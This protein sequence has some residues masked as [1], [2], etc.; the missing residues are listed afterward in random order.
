MSSALPRLPFRVPGLWKA[1]AILVA[2]V[3]ALFATAPLLT[4]FASPDD[5][6]YILVS[7]AHYINNGHLYTQTFSQY[8]PLYFYIQGIF[9]Q[10]LHLPV[11]HDM[12]RLV[13]LVYWAASSLLASVFVHRLSKSLVLACAA[14]LCI[15][16]AGRVLAAEPGHPQQVILLLYM[17]A[18]CLSLPSISGRYYLRLLLLGCVG[19]ALVFT[20]VNVGVFYVAGVAHA[21]VC[22]LPS[23]RFRSIGVGL[24]LIYAAVSPWLLMHA[25]LNNGFRGYFLLA[26]VSGIVTFGCGSLVRPPHHL[27]LRAAICAGTGL[28]AGAVVLIIATSVQG[29]SVGSLFWGVILNPLSHPNV[30]QD[31]LR[32]TR[33][34]LLAALILTAGMVGLRSSGRR[35]AESRWLDALRCAAGIG[36]ILL[37]TLHH[38]IEL[39][40]PLLPLTL[41]PQSHWERDA[42]APFCRLFITYMAVTQFLEPYPVAGSQVAIAAAPMILWAF[43]CIADGIAGLRAA[44]VRP[45]HDLGKG[46][47]LDEAIG[48]AILIYFAGVSVNLTAH[49][50]FPPASTKLN[51]SEWLHLPVEQARQFESIARLANINCSTLFSMPGMGSFNMWS[52]I[53][54]PNGWFLTLWMKGVDA[55]RQAEI[56]SIMKSDPRACAIVNR[57]LVRAWVGDEAD[58]AA[59]PLSRFIMTDMIK[60]AEFGD[61]EISVHPRRTSPWL[62]EGVSGARPIAD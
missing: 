22:L 30:Y 53:P 45:F 13:T 41:I 24:A 52:G 15:M 60:V 49:G 51:G 57:P 54:T 17:I 33:L 8:G 39:V 5:E 12:G 42:V 31:P 40:A 47:R 26:T 21:V 38:R 16:L 55:E 37:L 20:K 46:L 62:D 4:S 18:A 56:L 29:M 32:V 3:G 28:L 44:S 61:Y 23:S 19:A 43:L 36:S 25:G 10:L 35:L 6:G 14:G 58:V 59:L 7:L 11:N 1:L 50:Q 2:L 34:P 9:F 27:P 48:G